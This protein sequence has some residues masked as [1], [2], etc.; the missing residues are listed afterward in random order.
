MRFGVFLLGAAFDD[1]D[2]GDALRAAADTVVAAEAAGFDEAWIAEHHFMTYGT[3]PS[4]ITFAGHALGATERITVGTAV[5]VLSTA[6]P[7]AV[8]EQTR[9]LDQLSG[10]RFALGVGRGGPW[11]DLEVFGTGA[12][13]YDH[14][15]GESL[16]LLLRSL[17][18]DT[19]RG[20]GP[21]FA[22]RD[23]PLVPPP[24][25]RPG[26]PVTVACTS[27]DTAALAAAHGL[28][29]LLGMHTGPDEKKR[30]VDVHDHAARAA[31]LEPVGGHTSV[32][33]THVADDRDTAIRHLRRSLH[34]WLTPGLAGYVPVDDRP[35][36]RR[37]PVEYA[38][39]LCTLH[40]VGAPADIAVQLGED[41]AA[42]GVD[43]VLMMVEGGGS[44]A[45]TLETVQ[46]IGAEVLPTL[47][48]LR[49]VFGE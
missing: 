44:R 1:Q 37:D 18:A 31:G 5:S 39:T 7:V 24:R 48:A 22:F 38:E 2:P 43:R 20:E 34:R 19:V 45:H 26:P 25:S 8:A 4:A 6:H 23:V 15:F 10:G 49:P 40:P 12:G 29:M 36:T 3:C 41:I 27:D 33:L 28:P 21:T 47:R 35:R 30:M 13:R 14:G 46:R 11:V 32:V 16:D 42:T 9:M 17:T